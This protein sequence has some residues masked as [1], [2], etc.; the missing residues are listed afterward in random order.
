MSSLFDDSSSLD[1]SGR[2]PSDKYTILRIPYVSVITPDR[3]IIQTLKPNEVKEI[4]EMH[5]KY[6]TAVFHKLNWSSKNDLMRISQKFDLNTWKF[7]VDFEAYIKNVMERHLV[8]IIDEDTKQ[9]KVGSAELLKQ[10][11]KEFV[12][13]L[14]QRFLDESNADSMDEVEEMILRKDIHSY[15]AY[16][17][18]LYSGNRLDQLSI[19]GKEPPMCP[20]IIIE[21]EMAEKYGWSLE[22]IR[23]LSPRDIKALQIAND[24]KVVADFESNPENREVGIA[25]IGG[26]IGN[27]FASNGE[28]YRKLSAKE[29]EELMNEQPDVHFAQAETPQEASETVV[30][31][32]VVN[33]EGPEGQPSMIEQFIKQRQIKRL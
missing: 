21:S 15:Y 10:L 26:G 25:G 16:W 17:R 22:Y 32:P 24:Q 29:Q 5:I 4:E 27:T 30:E 8:V 19:V 23:T 12:N 11:D 28:V 9:E 6:A 14:I 3:I 2:F 31:Q 18:K 13:G 33:T 1:L 7:G 20:S